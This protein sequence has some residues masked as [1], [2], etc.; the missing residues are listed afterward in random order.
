MSR[1]SSDVKERVAK[2]FKQSPHQPFWCALG[3]LIALLDGHDVQVEP[4]PDDTK[5]RLQKVL[6]N[7]VEAR[8]NG[9]TPRLRPPRLRAILTLVGTPEQSTINK[10]AD[11]KPPLD[12]DSSVLDWLEG[13]NVLRPEVLEREL[14][15]LHEA[16]KP[17]GTLRDFV[18]EHLGQV[19][20]AT[21][22]EWTSSALFGLDD[23]TPDGASEA[24][25]R[26]RE[27]TTFAE[28]LTA[29]VSHSLLDSELPSGVDASRVIAQRFGDDSELW[30]AL[31]PLTKEAEQSLGRLL[32][33][34]GISQQLHDCVQDLRRSKPTRDTRF[35]RVL[36][37][38]LLSKDGASAR[39]PLA[40]TFFFRDERKLVDAIEKRLSTPLST[41][42]E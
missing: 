39:K 41:K 38:A 1:L 9:G 13:W 15:R 28:K 17:S 25:Q 4:A 16:Q 22:Q 36:L 11:A 3:R 23:S 27:Y 31:L 14:L 21:L 42:D 37:N 32:L 19:S 18:E 5:P 34:N 10:L 6:T 7:L 40:R 12:V 29:A 8:H 35:G 30:N 26:L 33:G 24:L 2:H 20:I